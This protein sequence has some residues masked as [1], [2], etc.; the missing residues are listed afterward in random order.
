MKLPLIIITII[1]CVLVPMPPQTTCWTPEQS[2]K[3]S[4]QC[5][6]VLTS[7][8]SVSSWLSVPKFQMTKDL[9]KC[10][11]KKNGFL[12][13]CGSDQGSELTTNSLRQELSQYIL[14]FNMHQSSSSNLHSKLKSM[15][16]FSD[17]SLDSGKMD[18][19]SCLHQG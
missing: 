8:N 6:L 17:L 2:H 9:V 16:I 5:H 12:A 13:V 15:R 14:L 7:M 19:P 3:V 10:L 4:T 1:P 11:F 18:K